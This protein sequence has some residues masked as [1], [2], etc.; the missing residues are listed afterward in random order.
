MDCK[1]DVL[2]AH[3]SQKVN[4]GDRQFFC[5]VATNFL[6]IQRRGSPTGIA[7]AREMKRCF[8]KKRGMEL[9]SGHT[10]RLV[11]PSWGGGTLGGENQSTIIMNDASVHFWK[12]ASPVSP[13]YHSGCEVPRGSREP[14]DRLLPTTEDSIESTKRIRRCD[15]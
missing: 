8:K 9:S 11:G 1:C 12:R 10:G 6:R 13:I 5:Y 7:N 4:T 2:Y 3:N 15:R 14:Q